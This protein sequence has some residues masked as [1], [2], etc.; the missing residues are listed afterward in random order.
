MRR[1]KQ[2][3]VFLKQ[4]R[5]LYMDTHMQVCV[6]IYAYREIHTQHYFI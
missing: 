5:K 4:T 2:C 1:K 3:D 6:C